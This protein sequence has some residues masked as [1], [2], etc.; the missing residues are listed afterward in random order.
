MEKQLRRS[1]LSGN[2]DVRPP[3]GSP[4]QSIRITPSPDF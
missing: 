2:D 3:T 4:P 1:Q